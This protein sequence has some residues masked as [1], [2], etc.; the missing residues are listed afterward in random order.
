MTVAPRKPPRWQSAD[1]AL[2]AVQ[3]AFDVEEAVMEAVSNG[4]LI[5]TGGPGTGKT[6]TINTIFRFS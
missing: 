6:T 4:L 5:I 1:N 3:V 2:R